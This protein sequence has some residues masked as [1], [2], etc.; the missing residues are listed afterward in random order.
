[1]ITVI[2]G[3]KEFPGLALSKKGLNINDENE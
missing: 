2:I 1:M 3:I